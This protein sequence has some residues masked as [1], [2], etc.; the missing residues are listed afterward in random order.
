MIGQNPNPN[1]GQLAAWHRL[2]SLLLT[3]KDRDKGTAT[4]DQSVAVQMEEN[5]GRPAP[6]Q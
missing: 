4:E 2:W 3:P 5:G 6:P 1:P